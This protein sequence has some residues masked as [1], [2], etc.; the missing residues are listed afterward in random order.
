[1]TALRAGGYQGPIAL[2]LRN[3]PANVAAP[4]TTIAAGQTTAEI[5]L[6]AAVNAATGD[7]ADVNILGTATA[8]ANQQRATAN[9]TVSVP[10][11]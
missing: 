10:K 3:L 2:E 7:K 6:S 4:K 1:V 11:K 9:F 5:E 8:A